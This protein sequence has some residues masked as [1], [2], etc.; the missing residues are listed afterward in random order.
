MG[1][2][3]VKEYILLSVVVV[4]VVVVAKAGCKGCTHVRTLFFWFCCCNAAFCNQERN[5]CQLMGG[6]NRG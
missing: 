2:E 3:Y 4:V 6:S 5:G 1:M